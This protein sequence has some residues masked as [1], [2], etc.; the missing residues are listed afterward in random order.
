MAKKQTLTMYLESV[1]RD[2]TARFKINQGDNKPPVFGQADL[3]IKDAGFE[4][5]KKYTFTIEE[6][7]DEAA[8]N[9]DESAENVDELGD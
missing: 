8:E 2:G 1:D 9:A 6:V 3:L 5:K 4:T 7:A